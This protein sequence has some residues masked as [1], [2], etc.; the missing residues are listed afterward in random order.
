MSDTSITVILSH[1]VSD[2]TVVTI[3]TINIHCIFKFR[4][5]FDKFHLCLGHSDDT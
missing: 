3:L 4:K 1:D 5:C 2:C